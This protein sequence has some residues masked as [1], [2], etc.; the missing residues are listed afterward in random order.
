MPSKRIVTDRETKTLFA[1][2]PASGATDGIPVLTFLIPTKGWDYMYG[3]MSHD[4]DLTNIGIPLKV[5]IGRC[6]DHADGMAM[7][8]Q[9]NG[10][11]MKKFK[12]IRDADVSFEPK[13][14]QG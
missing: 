6:E 13:K 4:F 7:L 10:G 8:G 2:V 9:A 12:D 11:D 1:I 5:I 3:G 14:P